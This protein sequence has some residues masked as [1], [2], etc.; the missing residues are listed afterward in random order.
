MADLL[1]LSSL[2][3][4]GIDAPSDFVVPVGSYTIIACPEEILLLIL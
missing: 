4:K 2:C 3:D 1:L